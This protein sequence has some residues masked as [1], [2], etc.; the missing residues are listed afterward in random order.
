[1]KEIEAYNLIRELES[2]RENPQP[3]IT[4]V[5]LENMMKLIERGLF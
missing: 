2:T 4:R 5:K 3:D 1:V